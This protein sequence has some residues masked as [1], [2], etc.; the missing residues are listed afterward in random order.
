MYVYGRII[1]APSTSEVMWGTVCKTSINRNINK[2]NYGSV[3]LIENLYFF[4]LTCRERSVQKKMALV[5]G[6]KKKY[7]IRTRNLYTQG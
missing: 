7:P 4:L 5:I 1:T 3:G 6:D 2:C